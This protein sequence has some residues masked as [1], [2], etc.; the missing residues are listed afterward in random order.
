MPP[1]RE[2]QKRIPTAT[3]PP[4]P[5]EASLL[6][7][8]SQPNRNPAT[9]P[10]LF[11]AAHQPGT[12]MT[13]SHRGLSLQAGPT[14]GISLVKGLTSSLSALSLQARWHVQGTDTQRLFHQNMPSHPKSQPFTTMRPAEFSACPVT[15]PENRSSY[16]TLSSCCVSPPKLSTPKMPCSPSLPMVG[17][18][19]CP[20]G[21]LY[22]SIPRPRQMMHHTTIDHSKPLGS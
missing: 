17:P 3:P 5:A 12:Y 20:N 15:R 19:A 8:L 2:A 6:T 18:P 7:P 4:I 1:H 16:R 22:F 10:E 21:R 9:K 13:T 11:L 14:N